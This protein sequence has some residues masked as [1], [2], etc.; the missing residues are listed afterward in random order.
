M[1][2]SQ[3]TPIPVQRDGVIARDCSSYSMA[4]S[5]VNSIV[6]GRTGN[7]RFSRAGDD[8]SRI[9]IADHFSGTYVP[10]DHIAPGRPIPP[11][12][13]CQLPV[14]TRTSPSGLLS[15]RSTVCRFY[16]RS[17]HRLHAA[18]GIRN[19]YRACDWGLFV[20]IVLPVRVARCPV[21]SCATPG[22][23]TQV[24]RH[25]PCPQDEYG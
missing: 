16:D 25:L 8:R 23:P 4:Y 1:I 6:E 20:A 21:G 12:R 14:H 10:R 11:K 15:S 22:Y 17:T 19:E 24:S 9:T 5:R 2:P 3:R 7:R 18:F 13:V